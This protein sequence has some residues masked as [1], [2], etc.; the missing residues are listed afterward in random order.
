MLTGD[1]GGMPEWYEVVRV[2]PDTHAIPPA[3]I[4]LKHNLIGCPPP[5]PSSAK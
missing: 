3:V 1:R 2:H 4:Q 5:P